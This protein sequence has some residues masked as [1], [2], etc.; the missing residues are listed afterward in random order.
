MR[1]C[2]YRHEHRVGQEGEG[3]ILCPESL[4]CELNRPGPLEYEST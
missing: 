4:A 3:Q 2:M 1:T